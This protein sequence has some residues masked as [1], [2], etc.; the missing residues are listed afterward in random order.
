[1]NWRNL[2]NHKSTKH[3]VP[4]AFSVFYI[5]WRKSIS[6]TLLLCFGITFRSLAAPVPLT[7]VDISNLAADMRRSDPVRPEERTQSEGDRRADQIKM[8]REQR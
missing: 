4:S 6:L 1:M 7:H 8:E 5:M 2:N 3:Y